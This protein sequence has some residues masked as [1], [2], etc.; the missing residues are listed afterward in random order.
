MK[1]RELARVTRLAPMTRMPD[2]I[3]VGF[4]IMLQG[5]DCIGADPDQNGGEQNHQRAQRQTR[6]G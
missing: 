1:L 4:S 3:K 2:R 5:I 6:S